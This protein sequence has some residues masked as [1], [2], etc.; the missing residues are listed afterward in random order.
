MLLNDG[1]SP[2]TGKQ[3]LK[4]STVDEMFRNQIE[5]LP[6]LS[7]KYM[8][9]AKPDLTNASVGLHPTVAGD[10]QG[11]GLTCLLSGGA[12]G[13]SVRTAQWSG[14]PNL[15]WWCDRENGVAG[16]I[17]AQVLPFGDAQ[18]AQLY[19]DVEAAVYKG[20]KEAA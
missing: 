9:D 20:L 1:T 4:K 14:L 16:M 2:N 5:D 15:Y 17:C 13:R 8:G 18:V 12:T 19:R 6:P 10:R 11:W 7:E 3:L